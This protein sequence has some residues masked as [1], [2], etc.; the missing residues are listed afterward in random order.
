[1]NVK[2][3]KL[4]NWDMTPT[5]AILLQRELAQKVS[6]CG[7]L[8]SISLV[9][10]ADVWHSRTSGMGRAAVVVLSYPDM[11]LVE[12]SRS[13][14]DCHIPYIPGLLSFREMP[15]LLSAFEGLE[16]MPDFILMDGQGLAHPRRL[17][18]AS[19]LGLF[20]N[21]PV[22]GCA[23]SR[24]VGEYAPLADEA[25]SYSDL[26]HNSQLVG[27]VLRTRRGVN[28]LFISVGHKICLEEACSRVAD[29]CRG[30]RLPE[31]LRHAHLAAAQLI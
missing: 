20:L 4:H 7:T 13:E 3:K 22:I 11:N 29:C 26:Y 28:P 24:L 23:K 1:M 8:S 10:G 12:V 5:E 15:L 16:S 30:Y 14:G 2:I 17:G 9:A 21:K 31:P 6:A 27:R 18:I 25:G 19:H